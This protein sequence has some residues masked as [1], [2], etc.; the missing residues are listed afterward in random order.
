MP[1]SPRVRF[2][3]GAAYVFPMATLSGY[4]DAAL[5]ACAHAECCA[6]Q[7]GELKDIVRR[8]GTVSNELAMC[9]ELRPGSV[10]VNEPQLGELD[11]RFYQSLEKVVEIRMTA[12]ADLNSTVSS[13]TSDARRISDLLAAS[14]I[15]VALMLLALFAR[16]ARITRTLREALSTADKYQAELQHQACYDLLSGLLNRAQLEGRLFEKLQRAA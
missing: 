6:S 13:A 14:G 12:D 7:V 15:G 3:G 11:V 1:S 10:S 9:A 4:A 2:T 8:L 16:N 5:E